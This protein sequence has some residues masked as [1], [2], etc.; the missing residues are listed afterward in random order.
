MEK[1]SSIGQFITEIVHEL[2]NP[3][4]VIG[5]AADMDVEDFAREYL[6]SPLGITQFHFQTDPSGRT[7]VGGQMHITPLGM[8]KIGQLFLNDGMWGTEQIVSSQWIAESKSAYFSWYKNLW[9]IWTGDVP[10]LGTNVTV[11]Y[12][13][14][15]GG[16][17]IFVVPAY[18][19]VVVFTAHEYNNAAGNNGVDILINRILPA[20]L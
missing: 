14:G 1:L 17:R 10:A 5:A 13:N 11:Y 16:Q 2:K 6:F 7:H 19:L 9:W 18:N 4:T 3:L 8:L 15:N 20:L 12:A